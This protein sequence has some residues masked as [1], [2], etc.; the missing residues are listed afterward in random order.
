[1]AKSTK[2]LSIK[3]TLVSNLS[4][5]RALGT[6]LYLLRRKSGFKS[7]NFQLLPLFDVILQRETPHYKI[8]SNNGHGCFSII[9]FI[10]QSIP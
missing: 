6:Q 4:S 1:M 5:S 9:D 8:V 10:S 7:Q 3:G 2:S